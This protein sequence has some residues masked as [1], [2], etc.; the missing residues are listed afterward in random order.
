MHV[1][2]SHVYHSLLHVHVF[3]NCSKR[4]DA[5]ARANQY[6]HSE[7]IHALTWRAVAPV[8]KK[9]QFVSALVGKKI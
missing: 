5:N 9:F 6:H 1:H 8:H 3:R 2:T 7:V 4:S